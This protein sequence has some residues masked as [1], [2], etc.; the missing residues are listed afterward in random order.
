[1]QKKSGAD[2]RCSRLFVYFQHLLP[3]CI[4]FYQ[5]FCLIAHAHKNNNRYTITDKQKY[6]LF[7]YIHVSITPIAIKIWISSVAKGYTT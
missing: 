1:M 4:F 6:N 7:L 5:D 3:T 2:Y